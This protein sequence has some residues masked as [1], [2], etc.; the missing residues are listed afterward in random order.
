MRVAIDLSP[1]IYG[2]GVSKYRENLVKNLLKMD[3]ENEYVLYG[4]SFRQIQN[5]INKEGL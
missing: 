5:L 1:I 4:G 3:S 2:T